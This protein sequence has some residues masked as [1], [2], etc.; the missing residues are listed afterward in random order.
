VVNSGGEV[1][2]DIQNLPELRRVPL[3]AEVAAAIGLPVVVDNDVN[4]LLLGEWTF[5]RARGRRDVAMIAAGTGVGGALVLNGA[6]VRGAHGYAGEIGHISVDLDGRAC[7]CGSR[8]CIKAYASGPDIA[9]QARELF[10][11]EPT[12]ILSGLVRGDVGRLDCPAVLAAAAEGDPI[13]VAVVARAAQALGAGVAALV[14]LCNPEMILLAGGVLEAGGLLLE[15][16]RRWAS[17]Y[18]F[19]AAV[20]RTEIVRSG[21]SK[22]S[23]VQGAAALFLACEVPSA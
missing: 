20:R 3:A 19:E 16:I 17:F 8:G 2:E 13:G 18:A 21:F 15:P 12:P 23:G 9:S 14:N 1:G 22:E 4:A 5:G 7:F 10:V 11:R 6:L